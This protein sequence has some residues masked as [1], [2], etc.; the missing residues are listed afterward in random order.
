M[1]IPEVLGIS[2]GATLGV[3]VALFAV[4]VPGYTAQL[5]F[6]GG[7]AL[8]TL[9]LMFLLARRTGFA[10]ERILLAGIALTALMDALVGLPVKPLATDPHHTDAASRPF[11]QFSSGDAIH[12]LTTA[13]NVLEMLTIL[14]CPVPPCPSVMG[15]GDHQCSGYGP[16]WPFY[17][18]R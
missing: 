5:L 14:V 9:V 17:A 10:P 12:G 13:A 7:G 3:M 2:A 18:S 1:A 16:A 6:A 4:A 15:N 8:A 11:A